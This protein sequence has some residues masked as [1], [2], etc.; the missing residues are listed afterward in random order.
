MI[1]IIVYLLN[2]GSYN[3]DPCYA[4]NS[5][6]YRVKRIAAYFLFIIIKFFKP[7]YI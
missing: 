1:I 4:N 6:Y 5:Q 7:Y 2:N 3:L